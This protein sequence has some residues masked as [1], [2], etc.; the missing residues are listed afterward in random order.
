MVVLGLVSVAVIVV[1]I[2]AGDAFVSRR[3][4]PRPTREIALGW[5]NLLLFYFALLVFRGTLRD[6]AWN[7]S[8]GLTQGVLAMTYIRFALFYLILRR[9]VFLRRWTYAGVFLAL[10][11]V[12]GHDRVL[13]RIPRAA[14][15]R[16]RRSWPSSSTTVAP[17]HWVSKSPPSPR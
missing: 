4:K 6:Y 5:S 17:S 1:G 15:H 7:I 14:V 8:P 9:L 2:V 12:D 11:L 16:G 3:L 10:E 13:R